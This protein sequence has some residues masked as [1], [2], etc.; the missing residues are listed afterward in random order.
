MRAKAKRQLFLATCSQTN[1]NLGIAAEKG[2]WNFG[3]PAFSQTK[4]SLTGL[5]SPRPAEKSWLSP[6]KGVAPLRY[7]HG[8]EFLLELNN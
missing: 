6:K 7:F 8:K 4:L 5:S 1:P 2:V 3:H